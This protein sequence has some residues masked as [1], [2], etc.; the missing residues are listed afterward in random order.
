MTEGAL[1]TLL[2][3]GSLGIPGGPWG[4]PGGSL[5]IIVLPMVFHGFSWFLMWGYAVARKPGLL[6]EF[7]HL[8]LCL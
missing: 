8:H 1:G 3:R 6:C 5:E 2:P 4:G 7:L